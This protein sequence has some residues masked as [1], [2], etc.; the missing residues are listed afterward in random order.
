MR[1]GLEEG[2]GIFWGGTQKWVKP[3]ERGSARDSFVRCNPLLGGRAKGNRT[4]V[5]GMKIRCPNH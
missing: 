5:N 1:G 3:E 4:P 2:R